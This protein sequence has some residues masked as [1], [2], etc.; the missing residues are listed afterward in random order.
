MNL[1]AGDLGGTKTF[2]AIYE[3][4]N[5][6]NKL[7]QRKYISSEWNGLENMIIS[8]YNELPK[9]IE[10]PSYGCIGVAGRVIEGKSI[11]TNLPWEISEEKLCKSLNLKKLEIVN[12]FCVLI[13]GLPF[14]KKNQYIPIKE[15]LN[16]E[17]AKGMVAIIGAGTGLGIARGLIRDDEI[18]ALPS[19]GGHKEF[20]PRS[21]TEWEIA[22][23]LKKD[24]NLNRLSIERIVSGT[25]L[26]HIS[27]WRLTQSDVDKHPLQE[28]A[29]K[30]N[31]SHKNG[32]DLPALTSRAAQNG[33]IFMKEVM[34]IWLNAYGSVIGDL[35]LEELCQGG[36]WIAG[37]TA[38]K[39]LEGLR[40]P[41]FLKSLE[42][43]GRFKKFVQNVPLTILTDPEAGLFSAACKARI[44]SKP[45]GTLRSIVKN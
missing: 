45:N 7:Y 40:S 29:S 26:G 41:N 16:K 36:I 44:M 15:S 38:S 32:P 30:W 39:N 28:I 3:N 17:L 37:G 31:Y 11:M 43:K 13:Y 2:L 25:G 6:L 20:S 14:F 9:S 4:N 35:A 1:L 18:I 12:D 19:E 22:T 34:D 23:W 8:F 33:D 42:N 24:L 5:S 10:K 21:E 27:R